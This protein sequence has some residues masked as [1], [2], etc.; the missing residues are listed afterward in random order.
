MTGLRNLLASAALAAL[1]L[2]LSVARGQD[3]DAEARLGEALETILT[4]LAKTNTGLR[5]GITEREAVR[6]T[7]GATDLAGDRILRLAATQYAPKGDWTGTVRVFVSG[8][9]G[10]KVDSIQVCLLCG[11]YDEAK[12]ARLLVGI[13]GKLGYAFEA[14]DDAPNT[15]FDSADHARDLWV[16]FGK[17]VIAIDADLLEG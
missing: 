8:K 6:E 12:V 1:A 15:W 3:E 13:G 5:L 17:G 10:A 7:P 2:L 16:S 14:D 11:A 4:R 9:P